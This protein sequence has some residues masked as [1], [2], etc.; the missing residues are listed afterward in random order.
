MFMN[1]AEISAAKCS[2]VC[3]LLLAASTINVWCLAGEDVEHHASWNSA[4]HRAKIHADCGLNARRLLQGWIDLKQ[5]PQTGLFS[6]GGTWDYHNEAAD[7]YSSLVLVAYHLD[8]KLNQPG[9]PLHRTLVSSRKLCTTASGL[10]TIYDLKN[11][12]PGNIANP[13]SLS[14]WL[15]DGLIRICEVKGTDND[16]Y[17]EMLRL[18]DA[19]LA[20]AGQAGGAA[21]AFAGPET[22][23]NML[24]TLVRL[25][26]MSGH[27]RYL[28]AAE[29]IADAVL[30]EQ[31][32]SAHEVAFMDHGCELVPGL[33]E[34]MVLEQKLGRPQAG[35]YQPPMQKLLDEILLSSSHPRTGLLCKATENNCGDAS[36]RQPPDTWGYVLFAY[37]NYDVATG[38]NRYTAAIEKPMRWLVAN[39]SAYGD[40]KDT[41]WPRST[42]SDD[43][44]D[45]HESMIVLWNR[46]RH[47]DGVFDWLDWVTLR[48]KHRRYAD[49]KYGP[50]DG[51]H[52]DG[53][54]GRSLVMHMMMCSQGV[55]MLP[56]VEGIG[57]G[58]VPQGDG[59]LLALTAKSAWTGR[60]CFDRPRGEFLTA[61]ID[62][63]R[64][65]EMPRWFVVR[66]VED[67]LVTVDNAPPNRISGQQLID[68][69]RIKI[70]ANGARR[71]SVRPLDSQ[72]CRSPLRHR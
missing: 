30:F 54:T 60:V 14:E 26:A 33:G 29:D 67:Y 41:L 48:H 71:I 2:P 40:L 3:L 49:K 23:G 63:A 64:L 55:R 11:H 35:R 56:F 20:A 27:S 47:V 9:N 72:A 18:V 1:Q 59:L 4:L 36:W 19:M 52:F 53:S 58:G 21:K 17:R 65:N 51:G 13:A 66:P 34:L 38:G 62:W 28:E 22:A 32:L 69:L 57:A 70:G 46:Y 25:H 43:W 61:N 42:S 68:G 7:H 16:W 15:R 5:D 37:Q 44:S 39:R 45:S 8:P 24:Q 12:V 10:P 6:R 50:F 31:G